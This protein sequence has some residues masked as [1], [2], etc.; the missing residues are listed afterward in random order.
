M[1]DELQD[2]P[3]SLTPPGAT[4]LPMVSNAAPSIGSPVFQ[5]ADSF[6]AREEGGITRDDGTGHAAGYGIDQAA[7]PEVDVTKLTPQQAQQIRFGY[8]RAIN[9][10][11]VAQVN[12]K[13]ALAAYDT[14]IMAGPEKA[15]ELLVQSN[16]DPGAFLQLRS[17]FLQG[18]VAKEPQHYGAVAKGWA[19]RD[20][21]LA[22]TLGAPF[23]PNQGFSFGYQTADNSSL[24]L[25]RLQPQ[26]PMNA[27]QPIGEA[28]VANAQRQQAVATQPQRGGPPIQPPP[29]GPLGLAPQPV[30]VKPPPST[31][32]HYLALLRAGRQPEAAS[33]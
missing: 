26:E 5:W 18:L 1:A 6:T 14:A 7:H 32:E 33:G 2:Q 31:M 19:L 12:P 24:T 29:P 8:W 16:G 10:D 20:Q 27:L 15:K 30:E 9:G 25:P 17:A 13:L 21:R 3:P 22:A 11:A 28:A 23:D 4:P